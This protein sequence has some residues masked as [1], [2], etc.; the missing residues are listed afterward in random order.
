MI[1]VNVNK[2]ARWWSADRV[3]CTIVT[4]AKN[5]ASRFNEIP[6][7]LNLKTIVPHLFIQQIYINAH[8]TQTTERKDNEKIEM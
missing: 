1:T 2:E 8:D 7:I 6:K 5:V 4:L 3:V